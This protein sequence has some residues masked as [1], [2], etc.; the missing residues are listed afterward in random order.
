[1]K[2]KILFTVSH[3]SFLATCAAAPSASDIIGVA[4]NI[5]TSDG[6]KMIG[7]EITK[8]DKLKKTADGFKNYVLEIINGTRDKNNVLQD[9]EKR[10]FRY[11]DRYNYEKLKGFDIVVDGQDHKIEISMSSPR[12]VL[13]LTELLVQSI[14]DR[15]ENEKIH[16]QMS[17]I[18]KK[19]EW[20]LNADNQDL[21]KIICK[22]YDIIYNMLQKW[23]DLL[24]DR[25]SELKAIIGN[26]MFFIRVSAGTVK[27]N[28]Y[29]D[30]HEDE[31]IKCKHDLEA[32]Y[33]N[34]G[35]ID[36]PE[37]LVYGLRAGVGVTQEKRL[38]KYAG[39]YITH[40]STGVKAKVGI[41]V[42]AIVNDVISVNVEAGVKVSKETK[43]LNMRSIAT[44]QE[45]V[46]S[47]QSYS[48]FKDIL[49]SLLGELK[50]LK[51][52]LYNLNARLK[53]MGVITNDLS[54]YFDTGKYTTEYI[55]SIE[56]GARVPV[57]SSVLGDIGLDASLCYKLSRHKMKTQVP[58]NIKN[59]AVIL[60]NQEYSLSLVKMFNSGKSFS[61]VLNEKYLE[62]EQIVTDKGI[63]TVA[64]IQHYIEVYLT[65]LRFMYKED[66]ESIEFGRNLKHNVE[67]QLST[68]GRKETAEFF[69]QVIAYFCYNGKD[70]T[71]NSCDVKELTVI[72]DSLML[73][74]DT[75]E[76]SRS[77]FEH[78]KSLRSKKT[79]SGEVTANICFGQ[80]IDF[81]C[82]FNKRKPH[83]YDNG[84]IMH[85]D[86]DCKMLNWVNS[87]CV[88][89]LPVNEQV[90]RLLGGEISNEN[91]K[92]TSNVLF[93]IFDE[94]GAKA[95]SMLENKV[96]LPGKYISSGLSLL[97]KSVEQLKDK[98]FD[99][100]KFLGNKK[101]IEWLTDF[102]L[103]NSVVKIDFVANSMEEKFPIM[104]KISSISSDSTERAL[105]INGGSVTVKEPTIIFIN[106]LTVYELV[107]GFINYA[108]EYEANHGVRVNMDIANNFI[109][110]YKFTDC[111]IKS[112]KV[113]AL[114]ASYMKYVNATK[115]ESD[116]LKT[117]KGE[118]DE[119]IKRCLSMLVYHYYLDKARPFF[120]SSFK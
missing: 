90:K 82:Q 106:T 11:V 67:S 83:I 100:C 47:N 4:K 33:H 88:S 91:G 68:R 41:A 112:A 49:T 65:A 13:K 8:S 85:V 34:A 84:Q 111:L 96:K 9:I 105:K 103:K 30:K 60:N 113:G 93:R 57:K 14:I 86:V 109:E 27:L 26:L 21:D 87:V 1:M 29:F 104:T 71:G 97:S 6:V 10:E 25:L 44:L 115:H 120:E 39:R 95:G 80:M 62:F 119:N 7:S 32:M 24:D 118:S 31:L 89:K 46:F 98:L 66:D 94:I 64:D 23:S 63:H 42:D 22:N 58:E 116:F 2:F 55:K 5:I 59:Y 102:N 12:N 20:L 81:Y 73:L 107:K 17:N 50:Y 52:N 99:N 16:E 117:L 45:D 54:Y 18:L 101:S 74:I 40:E 79:Y 69:A 61:K 77:V 28:R 92:L 51:T 78:K 48:K 43:Y 76:D 53:T 56:F 72:K 75:L 15:E 114:N 35:I 110:K 19:I 108:T 37:N 3:I 70:L 36:L 38:G